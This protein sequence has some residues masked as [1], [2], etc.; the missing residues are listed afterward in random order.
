[1]RAAPSTVSA[2]MIGQSSRFLSSAI[3]FFVMQN[4]HAQAHERTSV[5][6]R[7]NAYFAHPTCLPEGSSGASTGLNRDRAATHRAPPAFRSG[8]RCLFLGPPK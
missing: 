3:R 5:A 7:G 6:Q 8:A 4:K 2:L 1:M